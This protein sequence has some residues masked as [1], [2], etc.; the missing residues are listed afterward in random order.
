MSMMMI[1]RIILAG[2]RD[3]I[4]C[5]RGKHYTNPAGNCVHCG[6]HV[7]ETGYPKK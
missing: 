4:N 7:E 3:R 6:R 5:L 1:I 2:I